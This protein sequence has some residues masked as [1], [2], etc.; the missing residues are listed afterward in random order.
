MQAG[1]VA[2]GRIA[3]AGFA[4]QLLVATR[5]RRG[6]SAPAR[7][8]G[9]VTISVS[10][11]MRWNL[12]LPS[13]KLGLARGALAFDPGDRVLHRLDRIV[14]RGL[15]RLLVLAACRRPS[16]RPCRRPDNIRRSRRTPTWH[17][18]RSWSA[19]GVL[20][21]ARICSAARGTFCEE[22]DVRLQPLLLRRV[23]HGDVDRRVEH[24]EIGGRIVVRAGRRRSGSI[25]NNWPLATATR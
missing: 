12:S 14:G 9:V 25:Q 13:A 5:G 3:R 23:G 8:T 6:R 7:S 15:Q 20:I 11:S 10:A 24:A 16:T 18:R 22:L 1:I 17:N 19:I 4:Q 2:P 21:L